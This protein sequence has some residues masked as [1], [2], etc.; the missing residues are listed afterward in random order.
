MKVLKSGYEIGKIKS[1]WWVVLKVLMQYFS[2]DGRFTRFFGH[3]FVMLNHFRH[4]VKISF[5]FYLLS[6]I[7]A[8]IKDHIK[9]PK[10][11]RCSMR[12][13]CF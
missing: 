4:N 5:S 8:N 6:S 11:I 9:D 12:V 7:N 2:M 13:C 10:K 1:L 3:D